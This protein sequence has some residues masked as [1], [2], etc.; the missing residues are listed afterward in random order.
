MDSFARCS[1]IH[2]GVDMDINM[3]DEHIVSTAQL[4]AFLKGVD[5]AQ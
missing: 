2:T 4:T 5:Y 1:V 3:N